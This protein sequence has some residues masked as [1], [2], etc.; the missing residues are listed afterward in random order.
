VTVLL[1]SFVSLLTLFSVWKVGQQVSM[2]ACSADGPSYDSTGW[3]GCQVDTG[4]SIG[5]QMNI[6]RE[7]QIVGALGAA[8]IALEKFV[9]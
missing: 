5:I 8:L 6:Y 9:P 1:D 3:H 2:P 7:P 4:E